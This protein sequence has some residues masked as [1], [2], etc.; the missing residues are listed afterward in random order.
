[1]NK[2]KLDYPNDFWETSSDCIPFI[3]TWWK[4][5]D[6]SWKSAPIPLILISSAMI[7]IQTSYIV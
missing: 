2:T 7:F 6:T 1:M 5:I 4:R 3:S